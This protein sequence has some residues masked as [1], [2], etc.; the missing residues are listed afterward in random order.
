VILRREVLSSHTGSNPV[1]TTN[2]WGGQK[3]PFKEQGGGGCR[4]GLKGGVLGGVGRVSLNPY[5]PGVYRAGYMRF[6]RT[7][8]FF[9]I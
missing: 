5:D 9:A 7:V 3:P 1:L 6:S 2:A 4:K 8:R